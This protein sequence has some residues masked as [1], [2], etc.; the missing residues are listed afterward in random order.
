M[1]DQ[2]MQHTAQHNGKGSEAGKT[3]NYAKHLSK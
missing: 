2:Q 3:G 1:K